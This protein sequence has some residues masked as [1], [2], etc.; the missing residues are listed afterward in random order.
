MSETETL[1]PCPFCGGTGYVQEGDR[2]FFVSCGDCFCCVGE[3]YDRSAMPSH[4]FLSAE[5]AIAAWNRRALPS[6]SDVL[7]EAAAKNDAMAKRLRLL[8]RDLADYAKAHAEGGYEYLEQTAA[9]IRALKKDTDN[10]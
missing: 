10:G 1:E 3:A 5:E 9:A 4:M 6:R 2:R 7:E 8:A